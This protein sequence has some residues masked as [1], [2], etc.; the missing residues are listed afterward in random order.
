ME[1]SAKSGQNVDEAF[2]QIARIVISNLKPEDI[3][4][5]TVDLDVDE[6]P[7]EDCGC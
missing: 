6:K 5:E 7:K 4:Y 1:T 2:E 3:Q